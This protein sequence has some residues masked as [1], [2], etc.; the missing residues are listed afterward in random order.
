MKFFELLSKRFL[1]KSSYCRVKTM[2]V[3]VRLIEENMVPRTLYLE[4]LERVIGRFRDVSAMVRKQ[5][6]KLFSNMFIIFGLI[7]NVDEKKGEKF[8]NLE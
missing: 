8:L 3:F 6:L 4:L 2:K 1:D 7:Y 5:S